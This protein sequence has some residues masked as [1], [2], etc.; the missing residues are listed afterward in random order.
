MKQI[1]PPPY[2]TRRTTAFDAEAARFYRERFVPLIRRR[3]KSHHL[4]GFRQSFIVDTVAENKRRFPYFLR[5]DIRL[6]Y[7]N[8]R[9]SDIHLQTVM[10]Y[11][12]L[13]SL[14]RVPVE[15]ERQSR[16]LCKRFFESLPS[17]KGLPLGNALSAILAPVILIPLWLEIRNRFSVPFIVFMDDILLFARNERQVAELYEFLLIRLDEGYDLEL[18]ME[19]TRSGRFA[20]TSFDF[21]GWHFGGGYARISDEK[22]KAF[23]ERFTQGLCRDRGKPLRALIKNANRRIDGF[24]HH[25]KYGSVG[26]QYEMLDKWIRRQMR[27]AIQGRNLHVSRTNSGLEQLGLH[28]LD[29]IYRRNRRPTTEGRPLRPVRACNTAQPSTHLLSASP[30]IELQLERIAKQLDRV[31]ELLKKQNK[32]LEL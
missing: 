30:N 4:A 6:Y 3:I 28:S 29:G 7:P 13:L 19:K 1:K 15:F 16:T 31:L 18:N 25:Y 12:K 20:G 24:G 21:C 22:T 10:A 14:P 27:M 17:H 11:K 23:M 5:T 2:T 26:K 8:I 9:H 32:L